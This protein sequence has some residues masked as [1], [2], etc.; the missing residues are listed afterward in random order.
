MLAS[1]THTPLEMAE[2][3]WDELKADHEVD[4]SFGEHLIRI[5]NNKV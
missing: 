3:V 2:A 4:G 5:R 1:H